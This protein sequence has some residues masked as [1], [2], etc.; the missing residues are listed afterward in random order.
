MHIYDAAKILGLS[1]STDPET[2][3]QAYRAVCKKYHPDVNPAGEDM[4]KVVNQAFDALKN[5]SGELKSQQADYGD[6]L[7]EALN[8]ILGLA[9]L[10]VE[11]CGAWVWITGNTKDHK[12]TLKEAGYKWASKK[13][14]WYYRPE[15]FRSKS[16]G[17]SSL[18]DIREKYGSSKP[19]R[20]GHLL[21][22][23]NAS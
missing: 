3:K 12:N 4:M 7:N 14:A 17:K 5:F 10:N 16:R 23:G 21:Q 13:K 22:T 1:N 11:I 6:C 19:Q 18:D 2:T 20:K 8:K 15:E 9:G